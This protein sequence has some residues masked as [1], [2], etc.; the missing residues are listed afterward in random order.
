MLQ[1]D[2]YDL[3]KNEQN[4]VLLETVKPDKENTKSL[5]FVNPV[6]L[7]STSNLSELPSMFERMEYALRQGY[8]LA[9]YL[10]YECG[11]HIL[12]IPFD[13][14]SEVPIAWFGVYEKP[15]TIFLGGSS[16]SRPN[17]GREQSSLPVDK[18]FLTNQDSPFTI[19]DSQFTIHSHSEVATLESY[20]KKIAGIKNY[21][22]EGDVYQINFTGRMKFDF[23]GDEL[24]LYESLKNK[25]RVSYS[26]FIRTEHQTILSLSPELF[27]RR[28][29]NKMFVRPMKGT[30]KR[31]RTLKEDEEL[32]EWLRNDK[33]SQAENVMIVDVLRNDLAKISKQGSVRTTSLYD[34][35]KYD[36]LFQMVSNI[37]SELRD[38]VNYYELFK[39]MF[40]S[41]SVTGAPKHRAM[42]IISELEETPR[43][44]YTG[45]IGYISPDKEA[46]FNVAIRTVVLCD[47][48]PALPLQ[49]REIC[50][51][52]SEGR[53][54]VGCMGT[55]GGIVW[56]S[57][58]EN[59]FNESRLKA[60]F[61]TIPFEEFQLIETV[62]WD[63]GFPFLEKHLSRLRDSAEYFQF[64]FDEEKIR[65]R[66]QVSSFMFQKL[67][68]YKVRL[69]LNR[70]CEIEFES[71]IVQDEPTNRNFVA[72]A[73]ERT[74]S[75][76][77]F[78]FH[79]TT[80]RKTYD[81]WFQKATDK[82]LADFIFLN[83]KEEI[84]EG[85]ISNVFIRK[86]DYYFT[87]PIECGLLNG[88]YRQHLLETLPNVEERILFL[89]DLKQADFI[90]LCNAIRG[91]REVDLK[92]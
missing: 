57:N 35:E 3:I 63:N 72:I 90:Y 23:D 53:V 46:V 21:I 37:E 75:A 32:I 73:S 10:N 60:N 9:G 74:N 29:G 62:L 38:D 8:Y 84:T 17:V 65:E 82:G 39:A 19:H 66:F 92:D 44:I 67:Q 15:R 40:P 26:S 50:S 24:A 12:E 25:Q 30:V 76:D 27:F 14:N 18:S 58:A 85:C 7:I 51:L 43:G 56:D 71:S 48:T 78:L 59:E 41:G 52:S 86:G 4:L 81:K 1:T 13:G 16:N 89:E 33:K 11:F 91:L 64:K 87:P 28:K 88:V 68:S 2:V 83:E 5:L 80:N 36:T 61:L 47:P 20:S 49:G 69:L 6:E 31:G 77:R 79:K 55:G 42:E 34:V 22:K 45:A 54:R 70:S